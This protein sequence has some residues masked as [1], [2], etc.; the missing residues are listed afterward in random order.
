[1]KIVNLK[2]DLLDSNKYYLFILKELGNLP[3]EREYKLLDIGAADKVPEKF[4]PKNIKYYSL[5]FKGDYDYKVDLDKGKIPIKKDTFDII[6]CTETL[7][8]VLYPHKIMEEIIR[9]AKPNAIFILSMPNELNFYIRLQYL[10]NI[11][12]DVQMPFK[13]I[14]NHGHIHTPRTKDILDFFSNY[15]NIQKIH[16]CWYSR[17]FFIS[18]GI[19]R[20]ILLAFDALINWLSK[21]RPSLFARNVTVIGTKKTF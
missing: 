15:V 8:H 12:S 2:K 7:E 21:I 5:D 3:R 10:F 16:Y 17:N 18:K 4:L 19:K 20:N 11:K 6:I 1:M 13:T 9:I 14:I